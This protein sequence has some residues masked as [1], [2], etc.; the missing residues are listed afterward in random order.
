M[1]LNP[2]YL[3][4]CLFFSALGIAYFSYGRKQ[5]DFWTMIA[6]AGL[7]IFPYFIS[8]GW[9]L[10]LAGAALAGLPFAARRWM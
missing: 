2:I 5:D 9:L 7:M 1:N 10:G 3:L 6:G 4:A 8:N